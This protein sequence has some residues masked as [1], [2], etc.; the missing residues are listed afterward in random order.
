MN[1]L[2]I[3]DAAGLSPEQTFEC[4]QCFRWNREADGSYTGTAYGKIAGI[5]SGTAASCGEGTLMIDNAGPE[6]LSF[7]KRYLDLDRD[8]GKIKKRLGCHDPVMARAIRKGS[9]IHILRQE[10]WE[11]VVSF[12][13]SANNNIPRIK[14]CIE[15]LAGNFGEKAGTFRGKTYYSLP[16]P[17]LLAG[18]TEDDL[19]CCRLGY[20]AGY[21]IRTAVK[22]ASDG[23]ENL[24]GLRESSCE[25]A[26]CYIGELTGVGPKVA[27]CILLFSLEKRDRFPVDVWMR[28]VM[29][30][31]Y[32]LPEDDVKEMSRFAEEKFGEYAGIAQQYLYYYMREKGNR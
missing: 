12:I 25:D 9:G 31:L 7:W 23:M 29:H 30:Q 27:N 24:N 3:E 19:A 6:D 32:G 14:K 11:T 28:K 8:Y 17:E 4:G 13:I 26:A 21:L 10:P 16:G 18:L 1:R 20:R 5:S 22:V 2:V 15:S